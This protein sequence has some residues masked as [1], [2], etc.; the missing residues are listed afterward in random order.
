MFSAILVNYLLSS[1]QD[2]IFA[3]PSPLFQT[4]WMR[5]GGGQRGFGAPMSQAAGRCAESSALELFVLLS[6]FHLLWA[7][8][9]LVLMDAAQ[10]HLSLLISHGNAASLCTC[11]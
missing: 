11:I 3:Q 7:D 10:Y 1:W 8:D 4:G 5:V 6:C 9:W 2:F